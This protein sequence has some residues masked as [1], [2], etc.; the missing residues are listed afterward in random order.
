[1]RNMT[2]LSTISNW[3]SLFC[4]DIPPETGAA[5]FDPNILMSVP[6]AIS[7]SKKRETVSLSG[8]PIFSL[9]L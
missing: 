1:M 2:A 5:V 7:L 8:C 3:Q 4:A 6:G 9:F